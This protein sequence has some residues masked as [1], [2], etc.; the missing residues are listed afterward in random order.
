M[1]KKQ[2]ISIDR[3]RHAAALGIAAAAAV[4]ALAAGAWW[5]M[6]PAPEGSPA[7][8]QAAPSGANANPFGKAQP[9]VRTEPEAAP[10]WLSAGSGAAS[11]ASL[12]PELSNEEWAALREATQGQPNGHGELQRLVEFARFQKGFERWQN[13]REQPKTEE[14]RRALAR[15]L[16]AAVPEH[17]KRQEM[18]AG[19]ALLVQTALLEDAE[20]DPA[21]RLALQQQARTQIEGMVRDQGN[22][23]AADDA[24][25]TRQV[26]ELQR[27]QAEIIRKCQS[28]PGGVCDQRTLEAE[29]QAARV[30]VFGG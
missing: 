9:G 12:F 28:Q 20:P 17:L 13:L 19:E 16:L 23:G 30:S 1:Q 4:V 15:E 14:D 2:T 22:L 5:L 27:R 10:A 24:T 25:R 29:M 18:M 3:P 7:V 21:R 26:Q 8:E 11:G 6:R